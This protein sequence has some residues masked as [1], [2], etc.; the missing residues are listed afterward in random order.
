[1]WAFQACEQMLGQG[2]VQV[3][4]GE[5]FDLAIGHF[6]D[7]SVYPQYL[8][9]NSSYFISYSVAPLLWPDPLALIGF[10]SNVP[11]L[12]SSLQNLNSSFG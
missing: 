2:S 5:P 1:M 10:F 7:L 4:N 3:A 12:S 8:N 6:H 9:T 11:N